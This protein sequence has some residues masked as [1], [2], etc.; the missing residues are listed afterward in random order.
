MR[1]CRGYVSLGASL[2]L[3][4]RRRGLGGRMGEQFRGLFDQGWG[5]NGVEWG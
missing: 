3:G 4:R 1:N 2:N 5:H